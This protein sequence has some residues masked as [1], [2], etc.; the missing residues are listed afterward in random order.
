MRFVLIFLGVALLKRFEW[1]LYVFG[2]IL[3]V[4]AF[5]M[6]F[7]NEQHI[8]PEDN[9]VL[10]LFHKFMPF[11]KQ[12]HDEKF[13][14][15][16]NGRRLATPL[17]ATLL[18]V[19]GSDLVFAVDSIPAVLA[20]SQD[21]FIVFTSNI[22]AILGLRSLYFLVHGSMGVFSHLKYGLSLVLMFIGGKMLIAH[23][24][25]IPIGVSLAVV[26]AILGTSILTSLTFKDKSRA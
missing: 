14:I 2:A 24:Y 12:A 23:W 10:K 13:F 18:V 16:E 6:M 20:I 5:R 15:V 25:K 4:T 7:E 22:F 8:N 9:A 11:T 26:A 3:L 19:E 1:I 17:F 21:T